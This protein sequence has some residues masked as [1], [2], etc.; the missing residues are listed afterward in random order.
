MSN[1]E[2]Q[3]R[4]VKGLIE[5]YWETHEGSEPAEP[6]REII[7]CIDSLVSEYGYRKVADAFGI[8]T[9]QFYLNFDEYT[10][11]AESFESDMA[12]TESVLQT[13]ARYHFCGHIHTGNHSPC[14]YPNGTIG[15]NV[16]M[17]DEGYEAQYGAFSCVID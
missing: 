9:K 7:A 5:K 11:D 1:L 13:R 3:V 12:L 16:S 8:K 4:D 14:R 17:L 10:T 15:V 6:S 2:K